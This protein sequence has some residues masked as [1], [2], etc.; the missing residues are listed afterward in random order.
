MASENELLVRLNTILD[1][2]GKKLTPSTL[3]EG[4]TFLGVKGK[5]EVKEDLT[6]QLKRQVEVIQQQ[7]EVINELIATL[8]DKSNPDNLTKELSAQDAIIVTTNEIIDN[9]LLQLQTKQREG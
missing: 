7:K 2:K 1:D 3:L 4:V 5:L 9:I 8:K 6:K